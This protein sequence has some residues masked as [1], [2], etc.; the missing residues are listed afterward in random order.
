VR[1]AA[2]VDVPDELLGARVAA[3]V[4]RAAEVSVPELLDHC[5]RALPPYMVPEAIHLLDELPRTVTG[6]VDRQALRALHAGGA[7]ARAPAAAAAQAAA[8]PRGDRAP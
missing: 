2:V 4:R 3:F 1:Q 6:K 8:P 7:S 5:S